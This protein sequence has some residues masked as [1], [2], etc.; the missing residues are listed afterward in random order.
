VFYQGRRVCVTPRGHIPC[1]PTHPPSHPPTLP[2]SLQP[3]RSRARCAFKA[4]S[5]RFA[6][7]SSCSRCKANQQCTH[8]ASGEGQ[9]R[10]RGA[11]RGGS[12]T[13]HAP[14]P[15]P[16]EPGPG[17]LVFV[18]PPPLVPSGGATNR[19]TTWYQ[20]LHPE[21]FQTGRGCQALAPVPLLA[22]LPAPPACEPCPPEAFAVQGHNRHCMQISMGW[23]WG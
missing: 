13:A 2:P 20:E 6:S 10:V 18:L 9:C 7:S 21:H 14:A 1:P 19:R 22:G 12:P 16:V 23:G 5:R 3:T 17:P 4:A 11:E 8:H 15:A